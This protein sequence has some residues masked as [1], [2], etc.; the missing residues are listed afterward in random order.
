MIGR[1]RS[2]G[3]LFYTKNQVEGHSDPEVT[4]VAT[5]AQDDRAKR[6]QGF[7]SR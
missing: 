7:A 5:Q 4:K 1:Q 6:S 2:G 3:E